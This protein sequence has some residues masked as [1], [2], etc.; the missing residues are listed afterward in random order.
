MTVYVPLA[1]LLPE[2]ITVSLSLQDGP[3]WDVES[4]QPIYALPPAEGEDAQPS[5]TWATM[6]I[7][8][9]GQDCFRPRPR[10]R[11]EA[12][13]AYGQEEIL[14][15]VLAVTLRRQAQ[16]Q[17][18]VGAATTDGLLDEATWEQAQTLSPF[19]FAEAG[20]EFEAGETETTDVHV[21][22][23]DEALLLGIRVN[24]PA[25]TPVVGEQIE[26]SDHLRLFVGSQSGQLD[27]CIDSSSR[28]RFSAD[29]IE[30]IA[31][32]GIDGWTAELR[33]PWSALEL[34]GPPVDG[35][36]LYFNIARQEGDE[37]L[38]WSPTFGTSMNQ[39]TAGRLMI[40]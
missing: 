8:P 21:C 15:E 9:R 4:G 3:S 16:A 24:S 20:N 10:L 1:N 34:D 35:P 18:A 22:Y 29:T 14:G 17:R 2:P 25:P 40:R 12:K 27:G 32:E 39:L 33:V 37:T 19:V 5:T 6:V 30:A 11:L 26:Q 13:S 38:I 31:V 36:G 28:S 7:R 23:D